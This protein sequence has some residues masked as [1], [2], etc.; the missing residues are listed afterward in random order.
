MG[1]WPSLGWNQRCLDGYDGGFYAVSPETDPV[2]PSD[3]ASYR[4]LR[5]CSFD[6]TA[7]SARSAYRGDSTPSIAGRHLGVRPARVIDP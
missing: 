7:G 6:N 4:V 3:G 2:S 5:G 1:N